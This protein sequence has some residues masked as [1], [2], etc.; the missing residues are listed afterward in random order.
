[1]TLRVATRS[2]PLALWQAHTVGG[3]LG[4]PYEI[5]EIHSEGDR[6]LREPLAEI[7][8]QG[9]FVKEIQQAVLDGRAEI[10]VH[11]A[12]DL[13]TAKVPGLQLAAVPVRAEVRDALV[14]QSL[15][16]LRK[17]ATVATSSA[18]R[19]AQL[20]S[21]RPDLVVS[22]VRGNMATRLA[23]LPPGGSL[24]VAAVALERLGLKDRIVE[25]L[26]VE[27]FCPQ[28]G[29][30]ALAVECRSDDSTSLAM[31]A[32]ID[33]RESHRA[34][35]AERAMLE[36]LGAGCT[37]PVG[38]Y[39]VSTGERLDIQGFVA[40]LDGRVVIRMSGHG[41]DPVRVGQGLGDALLA[42]GG[43]DLLVELVSQ[44]KQP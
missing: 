10:A 12:K 16:A 3:Q 11:S 27:S 37:L 20:L 33:H 7:G 31:L 2:S 22:E 9:I 32:E 26:P 41:D 1:M 38:A 24:F 13:P 34:I 28:V 4:V 23:Q 21:L 25:V 43:R 5:V 8:G 15:G 17:G 36:R 6:R 40:S 29:Q 30:G 39:A 18:R 19:R 42:R 14:G 44:G 35:A